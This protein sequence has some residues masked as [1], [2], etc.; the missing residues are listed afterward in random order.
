MIPIQLWLSSRSCA[1]F[2]DSW[3]AGLPRHGT[4]SLLESFKVSEK[5]KLK[6]DALVIS[7]KTKICRSAAYIYLYH[8]VIIIKWQ[9]RF[10]T[11][12]E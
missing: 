7:P 9:L 5:S 12:S 10:Y 1:N 8:H 2:P 4:M 6:L 11:K 3:G